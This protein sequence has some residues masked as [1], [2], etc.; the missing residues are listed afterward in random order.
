MNNTLKIVF[1]AAVS[2]VL[3]MTAACTKQA[4]KTGFLSDYSRLEA[5]DKSLQYIDMK[6]LGEYSRFI[7]EPVVVRGMDVKLDT[8]TRTDLANYMHNAI[9]DAVRDPYIIVSRPSAGIARVRVAITDI[10]KSSPVL[11]IIPQTKLS[12]VGLGGASM[13]G[14]VID[15]MSNEQIAAVNQTQKGKRLSLAGIKKWGDAKAVMDDWAKRFRKRL[16]EAHGY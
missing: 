11:N 16:D 12:G 7:V 14:E 4:K 9:L 3:T 6:R 8:K 15:S 13:E 10:E 2:L 1:I 5:K